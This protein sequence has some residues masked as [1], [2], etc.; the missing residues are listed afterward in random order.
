MKTYD[1][2]IFFSSSDKAKDNPDLCFRTIHISTIGLTIGFRKTG[3][4]HTV[5]TECDLSRL[6][7][8][9]QYGWLE[10]SPHTR[11][12]HLLLTYAFVHYIM[13]EGK[14]PEEDLNTL[15]FAAL[16]HDVTTPA[17]GDRVKHIAPNKLDEEKTY[18]S[19]IE[20]KNVRKFIKKFGINADASKKAIEGNNRMGKIIDWA[21]KIAYTY[22][23][24]AQLKEKHPNLNQAIM[25]KVNLY[26]QSFKTP[27]IH[28]LTPGMIF[29]K[30]HQLHTTLQSDVNGEIGCNKP[31]IFICFAILRAALFEVVCFT[32]STNALYGFY[33]YV[34][35]PYLIA[36]NFLTIAELTEKNDKE[37]AL[38]IAGFFGVMKLSTDSKH[39]NGQWWFATEKEAREK[40]GHEM[41]KEGTIAWIQPSGHYG[42]VSVSPIYKL[43]VY[44]NGI[45]EHIRDT[46]LRIP[47]IRKAEEYQHK[48][49]HVTSI[50][51]LPFAKERIEELKK[52]LTK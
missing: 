27:D 9:H 49:F 19:W 13:V 47:F 21:D 40:V 50:G 14:I 52:F 30:G 29:E 5:Y 43:K 17:F 34:V 33:G 42:L 26:R 28:S 35:V 41:T 38:V 31:Q 37:L 1:D 10:D 11:I 48:K 8:I 16:T 46:Q 25:Q 32:S 2:V 3:F 7:H 15:Y 23:D 20:K 12:N 18:A 39:Y 36:N 51:N 24:L 4:A 22:F 6:D 44:H 45:T